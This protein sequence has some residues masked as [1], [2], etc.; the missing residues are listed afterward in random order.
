MHKYKKIEKKE[1]KIP[2]KDKQTETINKNITRINRFPK[3]KRLKLIALFKKI[4]K[5]DIFVFLLDTK[6][7]QEKINFDEYIDTLR[8]IIKIENQ[9]KEDYFYFDLANYFHKFGLD[10]KFLK[11]IANKGLNR[12][13]EIYKTSHMAD[14]NGF[15]LD[16]NIFN[17][18][19]QELYKKF[20]EKKNIEFTHIIKGKESRDYVSL[21]RK[22]NRFYRNLNI[23]KVNYWNDLIRHNIPVEKITSIYV[24]K[25]EMP[26]EIRS[27]FID[28]YSGD[29]FVVSEHSGVALGKIYHKLGILLPNVLRQMITIIGQVWGLGYT[30]LHP[31]MNNW[32]IR[33]EN[34]HPKAILIDLTEIKKISK[35]NYKKTI[36]RDYIVLKASISLMEKNNYISKKMS[37]KLINYLNSIY[38]KTI[39]NFTKPRPITKE[40]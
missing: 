35:N 6:L 33:F 12:V 18:Y 1:L 19:M 7:S 3:N 14:D 31:H 28:H 36:N 34:N 4:N 5:A 10:L 24:S 2:F 13:Y 38:E 17:N 30:H 25:L 23:N 22:G 32:A 29:V 8:D 39:N 40:Y 15:Y 26:K 27:N 9:I 37:I 11:W 16:S 20:K 21:T